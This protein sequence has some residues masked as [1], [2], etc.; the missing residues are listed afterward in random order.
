MAAG[1]P[2]KTTVVAAGASLDVT[3]PLPTG[4]SRVLW[5]SAPV[6]GVPVPRRRLGCSIMPSRALPAP[7]DK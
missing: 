7:T 1:A 6:V 2:S 5:V 4:R 3:V